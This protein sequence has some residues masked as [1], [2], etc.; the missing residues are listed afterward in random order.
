[1]A[2]SRSGCGTGSHPN[3]TRASYRRHFQ[4]WIL[5]SSLLF[6]I[7]DRLRRREVILDPRDRILHQDSRF[8]CAVVRPSEPGLGHSVHN[9]Y[10]IMLTLFPDCPHLEC[11]VGDLSVGDEA[12]YL[13]ERAR[14]VGDD[15]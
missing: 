11:R 10:Y 13:G 5:G 7:P 15:P 1:M 2:A 4:G 6:L 3:I 12:G 8:C 9:E 14:G